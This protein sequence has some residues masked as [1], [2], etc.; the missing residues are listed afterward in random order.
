MVPVVELLLFFGAVNVWHDAA[1][2]AYLAS[3]FGW[4]AL[5]GQRLYA[6]SGQS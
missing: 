4:F 3:L 5:L 1:F 2:T 6:K